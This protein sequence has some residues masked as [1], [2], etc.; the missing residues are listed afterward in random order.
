MLIESKRHFN[1][2]A[3]QFHKAIAGHSHKPIRISKIREMLAK[4]VG[5]KSH[6]GL[7]N[8]LPID[9]QSWLEPEAVDRL[10]ELLVCHDGIQAPVADLIGLALEQMEP[11]ASRLSSRQ[12]RYQR[13]VRNYPAGG[14]PFAGAR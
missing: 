10:R 7:L 8:G 14:A 11:G 4:V 3:E 9:S 13:D 12:T 2:L 1:V 6:N 5:F